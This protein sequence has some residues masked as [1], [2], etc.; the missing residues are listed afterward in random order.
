MQEGGAIY[1][2]G[3]YDASTLTLNSCTISG[4]S[5]TGGGPVSFQSS[6]VKCVE[7]CATNPLTDWES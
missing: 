1:A 4:T 7:C 3:L 6:S 5:V 2:G